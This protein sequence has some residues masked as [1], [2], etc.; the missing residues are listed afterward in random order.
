[1]RRQAL[2]FGARVID[3]R[4]DGLAIVPAGFEAGGFDR[5]GPARTVLLATGVT[6][7]RPAFPEALH[8]E[9]VRTGRLRYCPVCHGYEVTDLNVAVIGCGARAVT[10]CIFLRAYTARVTLI[11]DEDTELTEGHAAQIRASGI[12]IVRGTPKDFILDGAGIHLA[13]SRGRMTFDT[14]YPALG[15]DIHLG[16]AAPLGATLTDEGCIKVDVHHRTKIPGLYAAGDVVVGLDQIS[17]GMDEAGVAATTIRND[18]AA[19]RQILR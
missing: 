8:A 17:R 5:F 7:R 12:C 14:V 16:L 15:S 3:T 11:L 9:A 4:V 13:V 2:K 6:N 19:V 1:M 18:L 10:E